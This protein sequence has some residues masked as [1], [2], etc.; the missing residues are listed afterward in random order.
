MKSYTNQITITEKSEHELTT[1]EKQLLEAAKHATY[2]SYSP[3]SHFSVGAALR[4]DNGEIIIG[5]NQ[6]NCAYPSGLCA[7]RTA[8]FAANATHPDNAV[9]SICIAARDTHGEFTQMPITPCGACR[10]VLLET[11]QR[12]NKKISIMLYGTKGTYI[13]DSAKDLLPVSFDASYLI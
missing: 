4:L 7:E 13:I 2:N 12:F 5:S 3:Y 9:V 1:D 6:E 11:E 10:Q 8:V